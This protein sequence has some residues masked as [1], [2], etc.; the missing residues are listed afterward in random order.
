MCGLLIMLLSTAVTIRRDLTILFTRIT[1]II[2]I[3]C[4]LICI[5][6]VVLKYLEKGIGIYGG[7]F[8]STSNTQIFHIFIYI[9][10]T[11][12]INLTGFYPRKI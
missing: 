3:N 6:G 11:A 2:L 7:L 9:I 12:I 1:S 8:H 10:T 4:I 5:T